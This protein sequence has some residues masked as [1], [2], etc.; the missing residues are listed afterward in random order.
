MYK[1]TKGLAMYRYLVQCWIRPRSGFD[2]S[3]KNLIM[4][5][6]REI[7][8]NSYPNDEELNKA[9]KAFEKES[10]GLIVEPLVIETDHEIMNCEEELMPEI[11]K[12][13]PEAK[14]LSWD[15]VPEFK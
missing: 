3:R 4:E 2:L 5:M 12:N 14:M 9:V 13:Y 15:K 6:F 11:R 7:M 1:E 8:V 10:E